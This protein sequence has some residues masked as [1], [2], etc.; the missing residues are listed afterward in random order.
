MVDIKVSPDPVQ[1]YKSKPER[2]GPPAAAALSSLET[3]T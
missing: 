2:S 1:K 3:A